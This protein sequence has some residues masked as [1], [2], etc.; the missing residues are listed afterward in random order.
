MGYC[1]LARMRGVL[2]SYRRKGLMVKIKCKSNLLE[3]SSV[4]NAHSTQSV[5]IA[6]RS[7]PKS[8][9]QGWVQRQA[10]NSARKGNQREAVRWRR[11]RVRRGV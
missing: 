8:E 2:L 4:G 5:R 1:K 7:G 11:R 10:H 9:L 3:L 6:K